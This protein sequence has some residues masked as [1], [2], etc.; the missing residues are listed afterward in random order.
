MDEDDETKTKTEEYSLFLLGANHFR[1][2]SADLF[3]E[4]VLRFF[5]YLFL[6][7]CMAFGTKTEPQCRWWTGTGRT[8]LPHRDH[9]EGRAHL[10][11][12]HCLLEELCS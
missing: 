11:E 3:L 2:P 4:A 8:D 10:H 5:M 12:T 9:L 7:P 6:I 1:R